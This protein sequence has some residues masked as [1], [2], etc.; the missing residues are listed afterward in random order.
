MGA[1]YVIGVDLNAKFNFKK[2]GNILEL[3]MNSVQLALMTASRLQTEKSDLIITPDVSEFNMYDTSQVPEL[4]DK[5]YEEAKK[6]LKE[7]V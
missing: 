3:L 7:V 5:G 1:K 6:A 2:P 4:I